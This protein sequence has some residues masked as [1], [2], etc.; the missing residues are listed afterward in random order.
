MF[1][2]FVGWKVVDERLIGRGEL[3]LGLD[4]LDGYGDGL[5]AMNRKKVVRPYR[6]TNRYVEFLA[7]V[8]Y[9]FCFP[10]R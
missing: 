7:V 1:F 10:Y 4:F 8:R 9:L 2:F 3:L 6:L 5:E